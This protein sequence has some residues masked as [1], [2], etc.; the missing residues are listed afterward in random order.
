MKVSTESNNKKAFWPYYVVK[1]ICGVI[2]I[3]IIIAI[4]HVILPFYLYSQPLSQ[5]Q[6][7]NDAKRLMSPVQS[8]AQS[9]GWI[10][11]YDFNDP[12]E[13]DNTIPMYTEVFLTNQTP[14][15][16]IQNTLI[17]IRN[18]GYLKGSG[19]SPDAI[20]S[21]LK[22]HY[23]ID[24]GG[25]ATNG[26]QVH[27]TISTKQYVNGDDS[28]AQVPSG[29]TSVDVEFDYYGYDNKI[30]NSPEPTGVKCLGSGCPAGTMPK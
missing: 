21:A 19:V 15:E 20:Q 22:N 5:S 10:S 12:A 4:V 13:I 28:T 30:Q 11:V 3:S 7:T 24:L 1:G 8:Y 16:V 29:M 27:V 9:Q 2:V 6:K 26:N 25:T 17:L 18:E 23:D 14:D